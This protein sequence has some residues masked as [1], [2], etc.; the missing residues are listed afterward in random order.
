VF[1]VA[2]VDEIAAVP[3]DLVEA[4]WKPVRNHFG[5]RAFGTNAYTGRAGQ[6]V[7]EEHDDEDEELYV[8]LAGEAEFLLDGEVVRAR[9]GTLVFCTGG[10]TRV[11]RARVDGTTV[12]A[13]GAAA[14]RAFEVSEWERKRLPDA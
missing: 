6:V 3:N 10:T 8:V 4:Q 9:A 7:I 12:L 11:A 13:V 1:R 2:H 14:G 5:I